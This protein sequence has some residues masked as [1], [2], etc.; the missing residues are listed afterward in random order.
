MAA[1]LD[2]LYREIILD[3]YRSPRRKGHLEQHTHA[4][5]GYVDHT[6]RTGCVEILNLNGRAAT[7]ARAEYFAFVVLAADAHVTLRGEE[8]I[9]ERSPL[10]P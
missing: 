3:H 2:D 1:D 6:A 9:P 5:R 8:R 10:V 7:A 4:S